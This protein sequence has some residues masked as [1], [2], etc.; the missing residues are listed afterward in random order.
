MRTPHQL[1]G[2]EEND[3]VV[4]T[5]DYGEES[6]IAVD[7]GATVDIAVDIVD[8]TAIVVAADQQYEFE[9]PE[10]ADEVAADNGVLTITE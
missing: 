9:V 10:E 5:F 4:R 7:F 2:I 1:E 6:V 8:D 3:A